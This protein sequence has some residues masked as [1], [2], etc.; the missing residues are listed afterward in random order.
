MQKFTKLWKLLLWLK[1]FQLQLNKSDEYFLSLQ[2]DKLINWATFAAVFMKII[3]KNSERFFCISFG[4]R[5]NHLQTRKIPI[6]R[7]LSNRSVISRRY[8]KSNETTN[9]WEHQNICLH[10]VLILMSNGLIQ[11]KWW[12]N[13][14]TPNY[15]FTCCFDH[16]VM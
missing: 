5:M 1:L 3:H 10:S 14:G 7:W 4:Y 16:V 2:S 13:L 9:L 8:N 15:Q 11:S 6:F 12:L